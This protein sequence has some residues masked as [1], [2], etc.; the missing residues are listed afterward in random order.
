MDDA[1]T[2]NNPETD[3]KRIPEAPNESKVEGSE[4]EV[5]KVKEVVDQIPASRFH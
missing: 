4:K 5:Q 1:S 3:A 2:E